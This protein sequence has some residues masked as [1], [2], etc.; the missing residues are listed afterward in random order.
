M[1]LIM[2]ELNMNE[3]NKNIVPG[4]YLKRKD[5]DEFYALLED[6][7]TLWGA[8]EKLYSVVHLEPDSQVYAMSAYN[9]N[10]DF[11]VVEKNAHLDS[12]FFNFLANQYGKKGEFYYKEK[13][14]C[15]HESMV[16][17][18]YGGADCKVCGEDLGWY[19]PESPDH[20]CYYYTNSHG[21]ITLRNGKEVQVPDPDHNV[22]YETYDDCLFCHQPE[23]R[24]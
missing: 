20:T 13:R 1:R 16:E 3:L 4:T 7:I 23:E 6:R 21:T 19:C 22:K 10:N 18:S 5:N 2:N 24:K 14:S 9:L 12:I 11:V 8:V 15:K 17:S